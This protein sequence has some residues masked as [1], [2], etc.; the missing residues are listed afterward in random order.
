MDNV[1]ANRESPLFQS[2]VAM[3]GLS[4]LY[5]TSPIL[6]RCKEHP[7]RERGNKIRC[8]TKK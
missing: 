6:E 2:G 7:Q 3:S 5:D 1:D 4:Y 8:E